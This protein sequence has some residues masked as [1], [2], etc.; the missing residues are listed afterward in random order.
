MQTAGKQSKRDVLP[1]CFLRGQRRKVMRISP[2]SDRT[3][4][5]PPSVDSG[6]ET[7]PVP[8]WAKM[9][10]SVRRLPV[11]SPVE[12]SSSKAPASQSSSRISPHMLQNSL[13]CADAQ[14]EL[15]PAAGV[16]QPD[17]AG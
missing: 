16:R 6:T 3:S 1:G 9:I 14:G 11:M 7:S 8:L 13:P 4:H 15:A 17:I 5:R 10:F 2:V 12:V